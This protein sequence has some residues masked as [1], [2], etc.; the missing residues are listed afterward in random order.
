MRL[1][2]KDPLALFGP[3]AERGLVVEGTRIV[4]LVGRGRM[5]ALQVDETFDA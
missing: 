4:E 3:G 1:W 5:P 2:I